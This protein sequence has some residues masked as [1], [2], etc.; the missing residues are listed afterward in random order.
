MK[1]AGGQL[2]ERELRARILTGAF[3]AWY[4]TID[5]QKNFLELDK[6]N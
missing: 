6:P 5:I 4:Q 1:P 3:M 2:L